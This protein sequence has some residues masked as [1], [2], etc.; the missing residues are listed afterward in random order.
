[1]GLISQLA[2]LPV[3]PLRF[4]V[5]VADKV[6]EEVERQ[7]RDPACRGDITVCGPL[8]L[9]EPFLVEG[10]W[11]EQIHY[12]RFPAAGSGSARTTSISLKQVPAIGS[13]WTSN[14]KCR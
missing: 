9:H 1:M 13:P 12:L 11:G 3:A 7:Q 5:W 2:L 4:T 14:R 6:A 8:G 10:E